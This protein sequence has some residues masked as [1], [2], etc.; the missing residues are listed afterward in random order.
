MTVTS[1]L[2]KG[3]KVAANGAGS[4]GDQVGGHGTGDAVGPTAR[5]GQGIK[6]AAAS[7]KNLTTTKRSVGGK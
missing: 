6:D 5:Q 1:A 3:E 2:I 7:N 4:E